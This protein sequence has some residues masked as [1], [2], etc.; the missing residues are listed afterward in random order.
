MRTVTVTPPLGGAG[1][2]TY[3]GRIV[4]LTR[5]GQGYLM[6]FDPSWWLT[7]VTANDAAAVTMHVHC[8]PR[9]CAP[10]PNDYYALDEGSRVLAFLVAPGARGTVLAKGVNGSPVGVDELAGLVAK[11]RAARLF[12]PLDSGM[13]IRVRNDTVRAFAQQYRP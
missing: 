12:E 1:E 8:A 6:R 4:S 3:F 5:S 13:W 11:G 10:V 9:A 2:Q 7:G